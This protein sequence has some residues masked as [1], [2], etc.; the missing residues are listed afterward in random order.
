MVTVNSET[1]LEKGG[2]RPSEYKVAGLGPQ[3][4]DHPGNRLMGTITQ[5][6]G[7]AHWVMEVP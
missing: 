5:S 7:R 6:G 2:L 3:I 4:S 1:L